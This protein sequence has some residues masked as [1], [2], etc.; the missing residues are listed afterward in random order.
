MPMPRQSFGSSTSAPVSPRPSGEAMAARLSRR[1]WLFATLPKAGH[2]PEENEDA[3]AAAPEKYRFAIADGAT[4][5]WESAAWSAHLARAFVR[6]S[7]TPADF[8]EWLG[9]TRR[10]WR[11]RTS[12]GPVAWY[13]AEKS[14]Q[15]S[16]A[17]LV[18]LEVRPGRS[19]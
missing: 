10:A 8:P 17:T 16:F 1:D 4:E 6:R 3:I 14:E 18:G 9:E 7:P 2:R 11:P 13:A 12:A 19:D 15:G 5:G